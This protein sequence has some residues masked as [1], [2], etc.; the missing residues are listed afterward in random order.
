MSSEERA[1]Y[2]FDKKDPLPDLN[3]M[4]EGAVLE[5]RRG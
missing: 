2:N 5:I 3:D 1:S 4:P